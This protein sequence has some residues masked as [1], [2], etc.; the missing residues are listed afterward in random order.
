MSA[1]HHF[2]MVSPFRVARDAAAGAT[3]GARKFADEFLTWRELAYLFCHHNS[4]ILETLQASQY[5]H[6]PLSVCTG[7]GSPSIDK[8]YS[9]GHAA[10]QNVLLAIGWTS[11]PG[12]Y[13]RIRLGKGEC[14]VL[15]FY[16]CRCYQLGHRRLWRPTNLTSGS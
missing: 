5:P 15:G 4:D 1:Y 6:I 3:N 14:H 2:G 9:E 12:L 13:R 7:M 16:P 11:A 10:L 8:N